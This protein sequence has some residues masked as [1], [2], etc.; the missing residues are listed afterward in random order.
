MVVAGLRRSWVGTSGLPLSSHGYYMALIVA[1]LLKQKDSS[2][3]IWSTVRDNMHDS[4]RA[5]I[6][7]KILTGT[8]IY[9]RQI[10]LP[11]T[12]IL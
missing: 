5:Q 6:K 9:Y 1:L 8:Y 11:F 12:N 10:G 2:H 7:C 4:R 3:H